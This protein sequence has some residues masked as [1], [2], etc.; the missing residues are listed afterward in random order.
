[1]Q[2][3]WRSSFRSEAFE[4]G[5]ARSLF[6]LDRI[7]QAIEAADWPRQATASDIVANVTI[8]NTFSL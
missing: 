6:R 5:V 3:P 1:M 2:T 4:Q 8:L 7:E